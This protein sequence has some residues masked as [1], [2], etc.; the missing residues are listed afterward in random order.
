MRS[1]FAAGSWLRGRLRLSVGW[2]RGSLPPPQAVFNCT[3]LDPANNKG[4]EANFRAL[5]R[6]WLSRYG[7]G[8]S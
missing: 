5:G 6:G 7:L 2:W 8:S 4:A 3:P 1:G